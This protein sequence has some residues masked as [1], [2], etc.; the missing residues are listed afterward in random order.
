VERIVVRRY[1]NLSSA[2]VLALLAC[3]L[4]FL[5]GASE[6]GSRAELAFFDMLVRMRHDQALGPQRDDRIVILAVDEEAHSYMDSPMALWVPEYLRTFH[7]LFQSGAEVVG[8]D[9]IATYCPREALEGMPPQLLEQAERLVMVAYFDPDT[10]RIINQAAPLRAL[11]GEHNVSLSNLVLDVDGVARRQ[12]L[13]DV[14][15]RGEVTPFFA[16]RLH[17]KVS[18]N[19]PVPEEVAINF[20]G[21]PGTFP[22]ISLAQ[23]LKWIEA[24]E[25]RQL[26]EAFQGKI[27]LFGGTALADLDYKRTP[28]TAPMPGIEL[29]ANVLNNLLLEQSLR[30]YPAWLF[31]LATLLTTSFILFTRPLQQSFPLVCVVTVCWLGACYFALIRGHVF[32][33]SALGAL[34]ILASYLVGYLFRFISVERDRGTLVVRLRRTQQALERSTREGSALQEGLLLKKQE[35]DLLEE[36]SATIVQAESFAQAVDLLLALA[37]KLVCC[38]SIL[39][40]QPQADDLKLKLLRSRTSDEQTLVSALEEGGCLSIVESAWEKAGPRF[41]TFGLA[42]EPLA[43]EQFTL[44]YPIG[45]YGVLYCGRRE[46]T[47]TESQVKLLALLT[48]QARLALYAGYK[49]QTWQETLSQSEQD[50]SRLQTRVSELN[51]LMEATL[52]L[53]NSPSEGETLDRAVSFLNRLANSKVGILHRPK[54]LRCTGCSLD[55]VEERSLH[56][57]VDAG[58]SLLIGD[59]S[60]SDYEC[61]VRGLQ[62]ALVVP[63]EQTQLTLVLLSEQTEA[64]KAKDLERLTLFTYLLQQA[65]SKIELNRRMLR[66]SKLAAVGQLAAGMAHE[67]NTPLAAISLGMESAA[68]L[69]DK[70]PEQAKA[71]LSV[72]GEALA[73]ARDI[74]KKLLGSTQMVELREFKPLQ[75]ERVVEQA[76]SEVRTSLKRDQVKVDTELSKLDPVLGQWSSLKDAFVNL[77]S[78]A[79]DALLEVEPEERRIVLS[80][81]QEGDWVTLSVS[82][83]GPGLEPD[84][85]DRVFEPFFTTKPPGHGMGLGLTVAS[86]IVH[87]HSG[88]IDVSSDGPGHTTFQI[89][90]PTA[91]S[92]TRKQNP[93]TI[94]EAREV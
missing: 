21:P 38:D 50:R 35:C 1:P 9:I 74:L 67:L 83:F 53:F 16:R 36:I 5:I 30:E 31:L 28:F 40:F 13:A 70:K 32:T 44:A 12:T 43:Q 72:G 58:E 66:S 52:K 76:L 54:E 56:R 89:K 42:D 23:V 25:K 59:F 82:D 45:P 2:L 4:T 57:L 18:P 94:D 71:R 75:V 26:E 27:V 46:R 29:H 55:E 6:P 22:R 11:F 51:I 92:R 77:I 90:L 81:S 87:T 63:L 65:L 64:F 91:E 39:F 7:E 86:D 41:R 69:M 24:D 93:E 14:R 17:E 33:P 80:V 49:S 19:N 84:T 68:L 3:L 48:D 62:S 78:N 73:R 37:D 61:P 60:Q 8:F 15:L 47:F 34:A 88:T 85:S 20:V 79:H 10:K